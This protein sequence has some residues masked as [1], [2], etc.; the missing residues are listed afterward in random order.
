M[1]ITARA[2]D[3]D[4]PAQTLTYKLYWNGSNTVYDTKTGTSGQSVTFK[5]VT[6]LREYTTQTYSWRVDISDGNGGTTQANASGRTFCSGT[7]LT[8]TG[9]FVAS[10]TCTTCGRKWDWTDDT[11]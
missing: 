5:N 3:N 8:C 9:P 2:Y 11:R 6:G 7:T 1:T 4:S 10:K